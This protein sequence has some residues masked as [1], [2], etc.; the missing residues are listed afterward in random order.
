VR[1]GFAGNGGRLVNWLSRRCWDLCRDCRSD[2]DRILSK[3]Y[4]DIVCIY[5]IIGLDSFF[6]EETKDIVEN[7]I[8]IWLFCKEESLNKLAPWFVVIGHFSDDLD[9]DSTICRRLSVDGM[10]EDFT[11]LEADGGYLVMDFL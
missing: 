4:V 6:L 11:I 2:G 3:G 10:D 5:T 7:E 1:S 8:T 9:D